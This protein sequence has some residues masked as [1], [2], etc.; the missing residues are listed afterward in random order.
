MGMPREELNR[1]QGRYYQIGAD[2]ARIEEAIQFNQ[3]RVKQLELDLS[4]VAQR[5]EEASRQLAMDEAEI[6]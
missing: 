1:V 4:T 2:I 5:S 6:R 3:Q